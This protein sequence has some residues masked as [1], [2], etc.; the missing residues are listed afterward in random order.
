[1]KKK[2]ASSKRVRAAKQAAL[3]RKVSAGTRGALAELLRRFPKRGKELQAE[4]RKNAAAKK[5][6]PAKR[7][8]KKQKQKKPA[9]RRP[10]KA[11]VAA[12]KALAEAKRQARAAEAKA[13]AAEAKAAELDRA[14]EAARIADKKAQQKRIDKLSAARKRAENLGFVSHRPKHPSWKGPPP[15]AVPTLDGR[16]RARG[17]GLASVTKIRRLKLRSGGFMY[18]GVAVFPN[19]LQVSVRAYEIVYRP[20]QPRSLPEGAVRVPALDKDGVEGESYVFWAD[21]RHLSKFSPAQTFEEEISG[22][23]SGLQRPPEEDMITAWSRA[24]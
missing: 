23:D 4:R 19:G 8:P 10:S 18:V 14:Y 2:R 1:M 17:Y 20:S 6:R 13:A 24:R 12:R 21:R 16:V 11:L 7:K 22:D 15:V 5:K 3:V 9:P